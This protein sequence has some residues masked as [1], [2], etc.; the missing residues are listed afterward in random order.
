MKV[1]QAIA[2][3]TDRAA[4]AQAAYPDLSETEIQ[5]LMIDSPLPASSWAYHSPATQYSYDPDQGQTLLKS[6]GWTLAPG[7]TVRA[8][9]GRLLSLSLTTTTWRC[10][11]HTRPY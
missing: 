6:A 9:G 5:A 11:R 2:Y 1:R 4:L 7:S 3:C 10:A 8:R